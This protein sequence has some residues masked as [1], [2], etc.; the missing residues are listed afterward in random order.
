M[1]TKLDESEIARCRTAAAEL[2]VPFECIA[3][4]YQFLIECVLQ[5]RRCPTSDELQFR[6]KALGSRNPIPPMAR[7]E[8]IRSEVTARNYRTIWICH[9]A[10][11]GKRTMRPSTHGRPYMVLGPARPD[12]A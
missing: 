10:H 2:R 4:I 1:T 5:N 8:L 7:A 3:G 12:A 11:K 6:F 9:G